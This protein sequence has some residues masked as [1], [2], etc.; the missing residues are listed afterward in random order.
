MNTKVTIKAPKHREYNSVA[1]MLQSRQAR[2]EH[3]MLKA[4]ARG[5][6][7]QRRIRKGKTQRDKESGAWGRRFAWQDKRAAWQHANKDQAGIA[8]QTRWPYGIPAP[9]DE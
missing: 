2:Q 5:Y 7:A 1:E 9:R 4:D 6:Y 8:S 3:P